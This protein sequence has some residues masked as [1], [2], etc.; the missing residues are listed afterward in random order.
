M[1]ERGVGEEVVVEGERGGGEGGE[2]KGEGRERVE[3][4]YEEIKE[5]ERGGGG[6]EFKMCE[7]VS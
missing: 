3:E 6:R 1:I 2:G 5:G 7:F 4:A